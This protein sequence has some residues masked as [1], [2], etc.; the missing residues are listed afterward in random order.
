MWLIKKL[1]FPVFLLAAVGVPYVLASENGWDKL[2]QKWHTWTNW[3]DQDDKA[4]PNGGADFV[5]PV[6]A[7]TP[8]PAGT[9]QPQQPPIPAARP[10]R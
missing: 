6:P 5:K 4:D 7:Q 2:V 10:P 1:L 3:G 8:P 9:Q